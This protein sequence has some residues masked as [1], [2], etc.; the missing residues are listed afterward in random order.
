MNITPTDF[1]YVSQFA[2]RKAAIVI[3]PGKEYLVETRLS[4]LAKAEGCES[5]EEYVAKLRIESSISEMHRQAIDALTTNETF[6]FRDHKP[7][8]MMR[9]EL[10]PEIIERRKALKTLNIWSAASSTGQEA[11]SLIMMLNQHFPELKDW[12]VSIIGTDLSPSALEKAR[13]GSYNQFEVNRGLPA[14]L[15]FK[16]FISEGKNW[17]IKKELR[18][19]VDFRELNLIQSWPIFP[20]LDLVLIRN[21][22]I[23]FDVPTKQSILKKI[24][25]CLRPEGSLILGSSETTINIDSKWT[26]MNYQD[27]VAYKYHKDN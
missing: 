12:K 21:V 10:I 3:D 9:K 14:P 23:Y 2:M 20:P 16:N 22:L 5:L 24:S 17:V 18:D 1:E 7:F 26:P 6:F 11:Y 8:E 4:P 15:L 19:Q 27:S 13:S 25:A